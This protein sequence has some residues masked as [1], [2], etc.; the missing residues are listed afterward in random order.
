[1]AD[2]RTV[3]AGDVAAR[4]RRARRGGR[5]GQRRRRARGCSASTSRAGSAPPRASSASTTS[6][7]SCSAT[8]ATASTSTCSATTLDPAG[9][10]AAAGR[11]MHRCLRDRRPARRARAAPARA[12]AAARPRPGGL[13]RVARAR[14]R[15]ALAFATGDGAGLDRREPRPLFAAAYEAAHEAVLNCLVAARPAERLD[16]TM[17]EAFPIELV[18]ALP[19]RARRMSGVEPLASPL[20][21]EVVELTRALIR[22]DTSNP[23]GRETAAAELLAAYLASAGVECELVGPDPERLNLIARIEG[24]RG[25]VADADGPHRRRPGAA[26]RT[27]RVDPFDGRASR[28]PRHRPRRRRHEGRARRARRRLRRLRP[29]RRAAGRAT[30]S[31]SPSPTRSEHAPTCGMSWLV[32]ERPDLRCDYALNEGGGMLLE[33]ADGRRIVDVVVGEKQVTSVAAAG[34]RHGRARLG[35]RGRRQP[36]RPSRRRPR[37]D[38]RR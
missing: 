19:P 28:R 29:R 20:R 38:S 35:S 14:A 5:R 26:P 21:D 25:A 33:L 17:Q 7:C 30:S 6:A 8:S 34:P 32:R 23:P 10:R 15:S 4:E 36:G 3:A 18:R 11:L 9:A 12:A 16:G 1:M 31:S 22:V 37:R 24:G 13:L 27:G 2:S